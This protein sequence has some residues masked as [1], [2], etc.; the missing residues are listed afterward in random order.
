MVHFWSMQ[1]EEQ[2]M[3]CKQCVTITLSVV[4]LMSLSFNAFAL[5]DVQVHG[6]VSQSYFQTT[7]NTYLI[8]GSEDGS[9]EILEGA[10]NFSTN[11][12]DN[13][14]LGLQ[15]TALDRGQNGNSAI[16]LDWGFADYRFSDAFGIRLGKFKLP[17]GLHNQYIDVD[18]ART[19]ILLPSGIY[20]PG[21]RDFLM[22]VEG[23]S[24]YGNLDLQ[25][26]GTL[27]YGA[28]IGMVDIATERTRQFDK[29]MAAMGPGFFP[30]VPFMM[31]YPLGTTAEYE[32][33]SNLQTRG[34]THYGFNIK[35]HTP[36][37]GLLLAGTTHYGA[38]DQSYS[39]NGTVTVP[40]T[41][42]TAGY[43]ESASLDF[44]SK[45]F[46]EWYMVFSAQYTW[47][48][49]MLTGEYMIFPSR[50]EMSINGGP[51]S[52]SES[53]SD[54]FYVQAD[55]QVT[56]QFAAAAG[57]S[58]HHANSDDP[59]GETY[60]PDYSAWQKEI[61]FSTRYD[62]TPNWLVKAEVHSMNG[63]SVAEPALNPDG[64]KENWM[65]FAL[66]TTVFF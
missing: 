41:D 10:V 48:D 45:N 30:M 62:I 34:M 5:D 8:A 4:L 25:S 19:N 50:M 21:Y 22:A 63:T 58:M 32:D 7:E 16:F 17:L 37:P 29:L 39:L 65:M 13:L 61:Y 33:F 15:L 18:M 9:F 24:V 12:N 35:W 31:G 26:M 11:L 52:E 2:L 3:R 56:D 47:R 59:D 49:L 42:S 60:T 6:F 43:S 44:S 27:G 38:V 53:T 28:F 51:T 20:N 1:T 14:R 40:A 36:V 55:Y 46:I 23:V 54:A 57:Y 66:K 64:M